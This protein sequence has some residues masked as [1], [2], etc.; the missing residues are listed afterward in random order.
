MVLF[1]IPTMYYWYE[2]VYAIAEFQR[3]GQIKFPMGV[4][5]E[6]WENDGFTLLGKFR[7]EDNQIE[8]F[9]IENHLKP[10]LVGTQTLYILERCFNNRHNEIRLEFNPTTL[11]ADI[12]IETPDFGGEPVCDF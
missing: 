8:Q 3:I 2:K 1:V 6:S 4:Y 5:V 11:L 7:I 10:E 9:K 12:R